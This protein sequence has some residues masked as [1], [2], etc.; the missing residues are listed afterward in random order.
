M[1]VKIKKN[2]GEMQKKLYWGHDDM[3]TEFIK[4]KKEGKIVQEKWGHE[5]VK[6]NGIKRLKCNFNLACST[7][8]LSRKIRGKKCDVR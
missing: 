5:K 4:F 3:E 1:K 8:L 6:R 2:S 7:V